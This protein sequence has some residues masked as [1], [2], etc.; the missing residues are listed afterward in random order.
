MR[1]DDE[2][3]VHGYLDE[4]RQDKVIVRNEGGYF[5][6][7]VDELVEA[8]PK[9]QIKTN[10]SLLTNN[11]Q[12]RAE[13]R[14]FRADI[15]MMQLD[16]KARLKADMKA[17]LTEIKSKIAEKSYYDTTI[18]GNYEDEVRVELVELDDVNDIIQEKINALRGTN[19]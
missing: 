9:E 18:I 1:I 17:I 12:L 2:I 8:I 19:E 10:D 7:I 14:Q 6:T 16:Y 15:T 4:I 3:Y 11:R 13:N 5:G